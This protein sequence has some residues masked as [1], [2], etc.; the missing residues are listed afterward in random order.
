MLRDELLIHLA[1]LAFQVVNDMDQPFDALDQI[2]WRITQ[3]RVLSTQPDPGSLFVTKN[4]IE[5]FKQ[6]DKENG[7][8]PLT[9][10]R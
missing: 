2:K 4:C 5:R 9:F 10:N 7:V 6:T 3:S 1:L 8:L